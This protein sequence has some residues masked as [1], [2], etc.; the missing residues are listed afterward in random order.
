MNQ[1]LLTV[2]DRFHIKLRGTIITGEFKPNSPVFKVGN[3][4]ALIQPN[5][6]EMI[7]EIVGIDIFHTVS[8]VKKLGILIK[9]F[10]KEEIPKG[11]E[12]FLKT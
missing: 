3:T 7:T 4:I 8:G 11:T 9:D 5:G 2:D 10:T 6:S 1:K 12:V